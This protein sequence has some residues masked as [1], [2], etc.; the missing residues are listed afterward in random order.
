MNLLTR[1]SEIY[2]EI[3]PFVP[4]IGAIIRGNIKP[5]LA[6]LEYL[7]LENSIKEKLIESFT[8]D[9]EDLKYALFNCGYIDS[10]SLRLLA[11]EKT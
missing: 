9:L 7:K 2:R 10:K 5:L 8:G 6:Y 4:P 3:R 1:N 11:L